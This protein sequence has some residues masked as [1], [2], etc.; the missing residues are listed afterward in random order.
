[1][2]LLIHTYEFRSNIGKNQ[3]PNPSNLIQFKLLHELVIIGDIFF[4]WSC[5]VNHKIFRLISNVLVSIAIWNYSI[6]NRN[7]IKLKQTVA[8]VIGN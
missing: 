1:V 3:H 4:R 8:L 2:S 5:P 7:L 6:T